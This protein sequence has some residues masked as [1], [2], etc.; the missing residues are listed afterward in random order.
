MVP[1]FNGLTK[2][3]VYLLSLDA[4]CK[5]ISCR[6][7]VEEGGI[8]CTNISIRKIVDMALTEN[9]T[10]VVLAHNHPSGVAL[11]S[12]E[13]VQAT[14]RIA[15]ALKFVDVTLIDHL[16]IADGDFVSMT[17]SNYYNPRLLENY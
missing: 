1:F 13:D 9:A 2:E 14:R 8:N 12:P 17:Q 7:V 5:L 10:S 11:P 16:V 4:A 15:Q 6:A 3:T